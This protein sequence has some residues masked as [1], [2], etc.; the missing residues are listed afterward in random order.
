MHPDG[1]IFIRQVGSM[2][3]LCD[4]GP[5]LGLEVIIGRLQRRRRGFISASG[6]DRTAT[7]NHESRSWLTIA[8]RSWPDCH[9]I[10]ADSSCD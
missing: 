3:A 1:P 4:R 2:V 9:A 8:V 10:G 6:E 5:H 7:M